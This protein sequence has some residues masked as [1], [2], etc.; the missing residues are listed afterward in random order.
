M[1]CSGRDADQRAGGCGLVEV[2]NSATIVGA[3]TDSR[4]DPLVCLTTK[5]TTGQGEGRSIV[6]A[7]RHRLLITW[8]GG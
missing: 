8:G 2:N 6:V 7:S 4:V 3:L 1:N 5:T